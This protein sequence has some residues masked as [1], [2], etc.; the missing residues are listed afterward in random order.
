M[1]QEINTRLMKKHFD[2]YVPKTVV[3]KRFKYIFT[4]TATYRQQ[5]DNEVIEPEPRTID[6]TNQLIE[7]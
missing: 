2:I 3:K 1:S 6:L 5:L 7:V 4:E